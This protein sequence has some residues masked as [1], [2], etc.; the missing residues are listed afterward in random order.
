MI[1][2]FGRMIPA[3]A[4]GLT[5]PRIIAS[6][7]VSSHFRVLPHD[8]DIDLHLNNGRYLQIIDVNR[9]E[10]L[11]RNGVLKILLDFRWKPILGS[12][13]IQFRRELRLW[14]QAIASTRLTGW[15]SRWVYLEHRIETLVGQPV[16][17]AMAKVGFRSKGAWAPVESL[18]A[19]LP[20]PLPEM[21]LP[22]HVEAWRELDDGLAAQLGILRQSSGDT[23]IESSR[24]YVKV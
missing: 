6:Q 17:I 21:V 14:D 9:M 23:K 8:I 19:A 12:T 16:A 3:A 11:L 13:T 1:K 15:D 22:P 4:R 10:F 20:I 2:L 24:E 7:P 18:R 5:Q